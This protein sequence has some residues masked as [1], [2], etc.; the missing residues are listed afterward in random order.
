V[1]AV[2]VRRKGW[3]GKSR[4]SAFIEVFSTRNGGSEGMESRREP[5]VGFGGAFRELNNDGSILVQ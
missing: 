2:A 1:I 4:V 3:K 5:W